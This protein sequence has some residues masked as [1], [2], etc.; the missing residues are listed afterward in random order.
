MLFNR[1]PFLLVVSAPSGCGKTTLL[2]LLLERMDGLGVTVSHTTRA[3]RIGE[4]TGIDY[5]FIDSVEFMEMES[6]NKFI[7]SATVHGNSY[8]TSF[9]EIE[10]LLGSGVD[11]V[12]YIDIQGMRLLK[13]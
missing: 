8:G 9:A 4:N 11:V 5:H 3:Q 6:N 12:L 13:L 10:K 2:H 7:E 1:K